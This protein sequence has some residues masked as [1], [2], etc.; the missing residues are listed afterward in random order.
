MDNVAEIYKLR[1]QV[2]SLQSLVSQLD[3]QI[4]VERKA[5]KRLN[6]E[7]A[8]LRAEKVGLIM[9]VETLGAIVNPYFGR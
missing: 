4:R 8:D 1:G 6:E 5:V 9:N 2:E 7:N 3:K